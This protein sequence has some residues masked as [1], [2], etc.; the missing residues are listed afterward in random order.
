MR[1]PFHY[2]EFFIKILRTDEQ[3]TSFP[4]RPVQELLEP[5]L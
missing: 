5:L 4:F 2:Y 1:P 3:I